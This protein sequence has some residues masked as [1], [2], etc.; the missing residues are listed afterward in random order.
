MAGTA[1]CLASWLFL[2]GSAAFA[3]EPPQP[4]PAAPPATGEKPAGAA[5]LVQRLDVVSS[6]LAEINEYLRKPAPDLAGIAVAL[7]DKT[8]EAQAV[9]GRVDAADETQAD[10]VE[11]NATLQK[12][13]NL[14]RIFDKWRARLKEEVELLDPW[15]KQLRSDADFLRQFTGADAPKAS[16][17][18]LMTGAVHARLETLADGLEATR[19]P[20]LRRLD[21]VV[22][23]D[24][25]VGELQTMVRDL[26]GQLDAAR[27]SQQERPLAVTAPPL[28]K[29]P[30]ELRA[31]VATARQNVK[32]L[33]E[34]T[35]DYLAINPAQ[36]TLG[37]LLLLAILAGVIQL[38]RSILAR[39]ETPTDELLTSHPY[40]VSLLVWTVVA[41]ILVLPDLPLG[42]G[43]LRGLLVVAL[44]WRIVPALVTRNEARAVKGLLLLSVAMLA[45][46]V[47]FGDDWY[48]R[49]V[50]VLLGLIA[51][52]L[53][54]ELARHARLERGSRTLFRRAIH[55]AAVAAPIVIGVG[56][57]AELIGA[58]SL[59]Q[60]AIG[61]IVFLT[62][63][64]CTLLAADIILCA[65]ID[66]WVSGP[67]SRWLRG[68]RHWPEVVRIWGRRLVRLLLLIALVSGLP[69]IL[70]VLEP[71]W[72]AIG[73]VMGK[74]LNVGNVGL[75]LGDVVAF[76]AGI[77]LAV[78]MAR[79]VRFALDEDVLPRMPLAMGA[80]SAASRLIYYALI[81]AGIVFA[82]AA[83]GVELAKLTIVISAL[84]V[85]IG[86]GLQNV[87]NNFVSGLI[88]AFERPVR[89]GDQV[90]LGQTTGRVEAIG[91]RATRIR[92]GDG[93]EVMV[94]NAT[95]ISGELTNWTLSDRAQRI[96]ITVGV[97]HRSDPS[98]VRQVLMA[99]IKDLPGVAP[100]PAPTTA[101]RGIGASS[102]DFSLLFWTYEVDDRLSVES[103]A[104]TR[105]LAGLRGAGID[106][107]YPRMDLRMR[108]G[109]TPSTPPG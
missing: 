102:L 16:E 107:P 54:R 65:V 60:Q 15:R 62:L 100:Q 32:T 96:E 59:G 30:D 108:D 29:P 101:F 25:R 12:L 35:R 5:E 66:A 67:G 46:I 58:R 72:K 48:G 26:Q 84:S 78:G 40:A 4:A 73:D 3:Q 75:S 89:E 21:V 38:R 22:E 105:V 9:L 69:A 45:Q 70:P 94:P 55:G 109:G 39:G 86:F 80:A 50:T 27:L 93:A 36:F 82:L 57:V 24:V 81:V 49:V 2:A 11:V 97:D 79:F 8:R 42:L 18:D 7:P 14:D 87:V 1:F 47:F 64:L 103:E 85:G 95:L 41:P 33:L 98:Q 23:A 37:V 17:S 106:I 68:V 53:F 51:L 91:L 20:L 74:P 104:R 76:V 90:T 56:L 61:G 99:A 92:T 28:W 10:L 77:A 19:P 83:S 31:P 71:V 13:K 52:L 6:R 63:S 43:L 88:L 34:G 44:L